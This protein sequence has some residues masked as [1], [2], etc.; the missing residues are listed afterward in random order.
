MTTATPLHTDDLEAKLDALTEQVAF[1]AEEA[2]SARQRREMWAE[3]TDDAMPIAENALGL[4]S[5]ELDALT[6][7]AQLSD[8]VGLVRRLIQVAPLLERTLA[9]VESF[10]E[11]FGDVMPITDQAFEI[12][13]DR[14]QS[15][16]QKGYFTFAKAGMG[17]ADRIVTNF[18]EEDVNA[19]GDNIVLIL[20]TVKEMTQPEIMAALYRMI[21]AVQRQQQS[22]EAESGEPPSLIALA[23]QVRDPDV[24][25]GLGRAIDTLRAVSESDEQTI[26]KTNN[27]QGGR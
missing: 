22:I 21:E 9:S 6:A 17:I 20:E 5:K 8:L 27:Q 13:T 3:L 24:R 18:S 10:S 1:L 11:L 25:R 14:F 7:D 23:K 26:L 19:L 15:A 16:D 2:R 4:V 12:I